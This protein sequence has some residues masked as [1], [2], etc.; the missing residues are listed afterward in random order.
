MKFEADRLESS[1]NVSIEYLNYLRK[2]S[3]GPG[4]DEVAYH[5]EEALAWVKGERPDVY[6]PTS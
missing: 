6:S 2:V 1:I 4:L 5:L 3:P